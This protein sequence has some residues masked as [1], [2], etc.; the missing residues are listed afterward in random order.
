MIATWKAAFR[1]VAAGNGLFIAQLSQLRSHV[2]KGR[3]R[4]PKGLKTSRWETIR[5]YGIRRYRQ[6]TIQLKFY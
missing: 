4:P 5:P 3:A 6:M 1:H 2:G